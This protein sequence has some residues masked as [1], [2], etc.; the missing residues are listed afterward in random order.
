MF[1]I[2]ENFLRLNENYLFTNVAEKSNN[3]HLNIR[4]QTL[5]V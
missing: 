4:M 1:T 3:F 5:F 2:N